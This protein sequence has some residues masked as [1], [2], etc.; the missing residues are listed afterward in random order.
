MIA[1]MGLADERARRALGY[2][3]EQ[4]GHS[5]KL[6]ELASWLTDRMSHEVTRRFT[7]PDI[8]AALGD[9]DFG[10]LD[11]QLVLDKLISAPERYVEQVF[12]LHDSG[13]IVPLE[14]FVSQLKKY[15]RR[16]G[17]ADAQSEWDEWASRV[18]VSWQWRALDP[19]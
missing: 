15:R 3:G 2:L 18:I 8:E 16:D 1:L 7:A 4:L 13:A 11:V 9:R 17:D 19:S 14:Q 10:W 6:M 5:A 12:Y